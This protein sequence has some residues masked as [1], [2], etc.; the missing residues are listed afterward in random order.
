MAFNVTKGLKECIDLGTATVCISYSLNALKTIANVKNITIR[1]EKIKALLLKLKAKRY[2]MPQCIH[3]E[4]DK[5][6]ADADYSPD[7]TSA[8]PTAPSAVADV[9]AAN[10]GALPDALPLADVSSASVAT[11]FPAVTTAAGGGSQKL[12]LKRFSTSCSPA[13]L[14]AAAEGAESK[15]L[16]S[17]PAVAETVPPHRCG[18]QRK[19]RSRRV[20]S[21]KRDVRETSLANCRFGVGDFGGSFPGQIFRAVSYCRPRS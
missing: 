10:S 14:E 5:M 8:A 19:P 17:A 4:F 3:D 12:P 11:P 1:V 7:F 18:S 2:T 16:S 20:S 15:A 13:S 6:M 9:P 21:P